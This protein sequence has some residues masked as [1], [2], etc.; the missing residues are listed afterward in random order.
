MMKIY[1]AN[2]NEVLENSQRLK[3]IED[4]D[5]KMNESCK[6]CKNELVA[7]VCMEVDDE[8]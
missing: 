6:K 8:R 1:D 4:M 7:C 2:E 5:K 3:N